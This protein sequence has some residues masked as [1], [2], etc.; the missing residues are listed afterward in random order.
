MDAAPARKQKD[1]ARMK[2]RMGETPNWI[3]SFVK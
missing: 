2:G 1:D 3:W